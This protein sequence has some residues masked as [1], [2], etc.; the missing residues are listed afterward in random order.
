MIFSFTAAA[1]DSIMR[2][3]DKNVKRILMV[4]SEAVPFAKS[5]GLAD[6]VSAL[7]KE[8]T[9]R[10]HDVRIV[11]P[12]YYSIDK[13]SLTRVEAALQ[14]PMGYGSEGAGLY[15]STLPGS[16]AP[17]Y[18]L[19]HE[20]LF[21]REGIYGPRPDQAYS[22][23]AR[24]FAFLCKGAF[25]LC[26]ALNW[27]PDILHGHDWVAGL[28]PYI[29]TKWELFNE[30][31]KT[32]TLLTI[33]NLGYQGI[34]SLE[35][36][37]WIQSEQDWFNI[38]TLE[39]GGA[40]NLL[41][42]GIMGADQITTVSPTYA[43]EIRTPAYGHRLEGLLDYR[44]Q[45]LIGIINGIDYDLWN[46]ETDPHLKP[47]NYSSNDL[48]G[49]RELKKR[50]QARM[51]LKPDPAIPLV[52]MITRLVEQKGIGELC[53]PGYGSLHS[54]CRDM[55]LQ[56]ALLGSGDAWCENEL[57]HLAYLHPNLKVEIGYDDGLAHLIEAGSDF[58]L[59]PS[60]YEPCGLNQLYSLRYGTPPIVRRTGGLADTVTNYD[61]NTGTGTGFC[62]DDL[63][64]GVLYNVMRWVCDTWEQEPE[65]ITAMRRRGMSKRFSWENSAAEYE[66]VY[67]K[68]LQKRNGT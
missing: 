8:L 17:V 34:S 45:D 27:I 36:I 58:F 6:M 28:V 64:P 4:T 37:R 51:G 48:S 25:Q 26:R 13:G 40:L 68:A 3:M 11:M 31:N 22:D 46:P 23:N 42:T 49:K 16:S 65:Q 59:M 18:F 60:R 43:R 52:G 66:A 39:F 29:H 14:V 54:I 1:P 57:R 67:D 32:A 21:G 15:R 53:G 41:K 2:P 50:L 19:E 38:S 24:R 33:H 12:R 30:F 10:G 62:F 7:T 61:Q 44:K 56:F 20:E 35:D 55:P 63:N 47:H 9:S 5:G